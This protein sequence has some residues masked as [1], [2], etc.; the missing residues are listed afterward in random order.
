[1]MDG[2]M[3]PSEVFHWL[4][5]N[6]SQGS[7]VLEFGSGSGSVELSNKYQLISVEHDKKWLGLSNGRYIHAGIIQNQISEK[8]SEVGWYD[9]TKLTNLPSRVDVILIDGPPGSIGRHGILGFV[10]SLPSF[11]FMIIDDTDRLDEKSLA[12]KLE[13]HFKPIESIQIV[14]DSLRQNGVNREAIILKMR[15]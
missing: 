9:L 2:W 11:Q 14:S 4:D 7:L 3:L 1:M 5:E 6:I 15:I 10:D 12:L 13:Q 8:F